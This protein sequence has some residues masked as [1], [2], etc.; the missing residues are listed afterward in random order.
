[1]PPIS[2]AVV[3]FSDLVLQVDFD[4]LQVLEEWNRMPTVEPYVKL[5]I[6]RYISLISRIREEGFRLEKEQELRA[7]NIP[8]D[9]TDP[10]LLRLF[11]HFLRVWAQGAEP[12]RPALP[13]RNAGSYTLPQLEQHCR[14]L[15]LYF[16]FSRA[17]ECGVDEDALE[18]WA[19]KPASSYVAIT[20]NDE[21]LKDL[22]EDLAKN[23]TKPGATG[24]EITDHINPC[25]RITSVDAPTKGTATLIDATTLRW[26]IAELGVIASEGASLTFTVQHAGSC[27]GTLEVNEAIEYSDNEDNTADF[28]SPEIAVNCGISVLPER[29]PTP[30]NVTIGGCE[31]TV[32]FDAGALALESLGRI[33]QLSVTLQNVC[34]NRRVALAA[35]LTEVDDAGLEH[36]RGL[37]MVTVPAHTQASCANVTVR[38]IK[39]VLPQHLDVTTA[40]GSI[41]GTRSLR[42]R[43]IANYI[44]YDFACCTAD[45]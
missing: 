19:S 3:G 21:E 17:F 16:S 18:D 4:L 30:V 44:D 41:C 37:K 20:P 10:E 14:K 24:I 11:F 8:F 39:F 31:D 34:P 43:F 15:D 40:T 32:E 36:Q 23:I 6:T 5:D 28:P 12:E 33:L 27:S 1:M 9:E 22:F 7:A 25:F 38:C 13:D 2:K 29:C 26:R 45:T 35:I 42:A